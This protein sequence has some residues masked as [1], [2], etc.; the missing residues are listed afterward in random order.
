MLPVITVVPKNI[1]MALQFANCLTQGTTVAVKVLKHPPG[2]AS[3]ITLLLDNYW[4]TQVQ[5]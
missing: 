3:S 1:Y 2:T 4:Q 5:Q